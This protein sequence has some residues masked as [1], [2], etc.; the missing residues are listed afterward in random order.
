MKLF[1]YTK[2]HVALLLSFLKFMVSFLSILAL[3]S[4]TMF[5]QQ[6]NCNRKEY[7]RQ[8]SY[9]SGDI[10]REG[11]SLSSSTTPTQATSYD[12]H[13]WPSS[14][15]RIRHHLPSLPPHPLPAHSALRG[16]NSD[17]HW[18]G[19]RTH[20]HA[21]HRALFSYRLRG[22]QCGCWWFP[23]QSQWPIRQRQ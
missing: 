20:T 19:S 8:R 9:I 17:T 21:L 15:S 23:W 13:Q 10:H 4:I 3:P 2:C 18:A 22:E 5:P 11:T 1:D 14:S 6:G 12:H 7:L 16:S